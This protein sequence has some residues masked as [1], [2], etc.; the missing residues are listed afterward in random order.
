MLA[1]QLCAA[2]PHGSRCELAWK[3]VKRTADLELLL[4]TVLQV[5]CA[6]ILGGGVV[7]NS[8]SG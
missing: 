5:I 7:A 1:V 6:V 2:R 4:L 3:G 8:L